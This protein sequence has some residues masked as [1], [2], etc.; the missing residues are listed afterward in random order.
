[1]NIV[2]SYAEPLSVLAFLAYLAASIY[3]FRRYRKTMVL[4]S[5]SRQTRMQW[6]NSLLWCLTIIGIA[7]VLTVV[8]PHVLD[9]PFDVHYYP[10]ELGLALFTYWLVLSGYHQVKLISA[11]TLNIVNDPQ[12]GIDHEGLFERLRFAMENEKLYLDPELN[13]VK[14]AAHTSIPAKTIS[15]ILNRYQE[16]SFNDFI[17]SYRVKEVSERMTDPAYKHFTISG[18]ALESGFNSQA[19][20]QRVFKNTTGMSPREYISNHLKKTA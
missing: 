7:W 14:V 18:I 5:A 8:A 16:I 20:F 1:M 4:K 17:N 13:L 9:I 6:V 15:A 19:T 2:W 3:Q 11:K 12:A 10:I